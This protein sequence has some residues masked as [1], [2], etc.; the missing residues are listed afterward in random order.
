MYF[1][2]CRLFQKVMKLVSNV[3]PWRKPQL[4]QGQGSLLKLP[5]Q[6]KL[7]HIDC[8]L[9]VTDQGIILADLLTPLLQQMNQ[10]GIKYV[11]YDKTVPNPTINNIEEALK[12]YHE[13]K[14]SGIV[15]IGGGSAMDCAKG[16]AARVARPKKSI[17]KMKGLLKVRKKTPTLFAVP[18]TSGTGSEATLA[19]VIVDSNT[20]EKYAMNDFSL[21]PSYAVLDPCITQKLPPHITAQ[22]GMDALTHAIEAYIGHSN[23]KETK[24]HSEM[25]VKLIFENI[26]EAY[27]NGDNLIAR[28][29]MQNAAYLAGLAF[30]RAYVGN[31]HAIAHTLGGFYSTPH[32]LANAVIMPYVLEYYGSKVYKP[33]SKLSK[34]VGLSKEDDDKNNAQVFINEIK[35]LNRKM[36]IP[37]KITGIDVK[38]IPVMAERAY[39]EANPLYPVPVI[40]NKTKLY[41][42]Y[43]LIK[44]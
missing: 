23:T 13:N 6:I 12:L 18:T 4:I 3:L 42:I 5:K 39:K 10:S 24:K 14:C 34:L 37:D 16:V 7:C 31:I 27:S 38:D 30:T 26:F 15:S 2:Y 21:I 25:A 43:Q 35:N 41:Y 29:N 22:T 1:I 32:G 33:L 17:T 44:E 9:I 19:A 40:L 36:G 20:H 11:T 28:E 8:V